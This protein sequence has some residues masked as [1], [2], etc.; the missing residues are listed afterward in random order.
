[1]GAYEF[2][3]RG[4]DTY[5]ADTG[6]VVT[7]GA[8]DS[9]PTTIAGPPSTT[10]GW[11]TV[12]GLGLDP[13]IANEGEEWISASGRIYKDSLQ[14]W[15]LVLRTLPYSFPSDWADYRAL[16]EHLSRPYLYL[17]IKTYGVSLHASGECLPVVCEAQ[18]EHRHDTGDKVVT[19]NLKLRT[20]GEVL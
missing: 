15:G 18:T 13:T 9:A 17:A 11:I 16:Q 5:F 4:A 3:L 10:T 1:M 19:L 20:S 2:Y 12:P 14:R 8:S 6:G 7:T